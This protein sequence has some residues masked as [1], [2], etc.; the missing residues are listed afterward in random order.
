MRWEGAG[1]A[2]SQPK[3]TA[4][5]MEPQK[6]FKGVTLR[7]FSTR[8]PCSCFLFWFQPLRPP[9]PFHS[10]SVIISH[11]QVPS[12]SFFHP[13][14]KALVPLWARN[15]F[16]EPSLEYSSQA[17]LAGGPVRQPMHT[18]FRFPVLAGRCGTPPYLTYWPARLHRL[19]ESIPGLLKLSQIRARS[20]NF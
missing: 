8:G 6:N 7:I 20:P 12:L 3:S 14:S 18:C 5:H 10:H 1:V 13:E 2:G 17:T 19:A 16:Q 11:H 4:V 9:R 15:R